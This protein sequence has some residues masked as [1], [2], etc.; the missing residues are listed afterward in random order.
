MLNYPQLR[1]RPLHLLGPMFQHLSLLMLC[2]TNFPAPH[3]IDGRDLHHLSPKHLDQRRLR[4]CPKA[5]TL[6]RAPSVSDY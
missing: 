3:P 5:S 4:R 2:I 1:L 6:H